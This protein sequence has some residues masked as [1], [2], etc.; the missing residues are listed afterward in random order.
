[1]QISVSRSGP[2]GTP[3][4]KNGPTGSAYITFKRDEDARKC[5]ETTHGVDWQGK[6]MVLLDGW[7]LICRFFRGLRCWSAQRVCCVRECGELTRV[8]G[9]RE[10]DQ[11]LL[12]DNKVLQ[13]VLEGRTMQ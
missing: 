6:S 7:M 13:C 4:V 9:C 11:S 3:G 2:Y 12:W 10:D 8:G 5:I 1:V